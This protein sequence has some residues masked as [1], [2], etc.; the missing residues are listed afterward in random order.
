MYIQKSNVH[1]HVNIHKPT[2]SLYTLIDLVS[3][4]HGY[5]VRILRSVPT[6]E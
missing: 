4:E 1:N 3:V 5:Y 6:L 2:K